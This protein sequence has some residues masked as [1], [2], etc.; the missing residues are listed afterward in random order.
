[1]NWEDEG[2]LIE[3][4]NHGEKNSIIKVL[5]EKHGLCAGLVKG[6]QAKKYRS[7]LS[8]GAQL[9]LRWSARLPEHL[10]MFNLDVIKGRSTLFMG[11]KL[12]LFGFNSLCSMILMFLAERE[13]VEILYLET[14]DLI[15]AIETGSNWLKSY[16]IWEKN[17][18][19]EIGF[20]LELS[21]CA[22][23]GSRQ[24][25]SHVSPKSGKA[26]CRKIAEP[27]KE[28]L[29]K[30]PNFLISA[31]SVTDAKAIELVEGL[32]LTG[33]FFTNWAL[34]EFNKV[35]LPDARIKLIDELNIF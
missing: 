7:T 33:H 28:R 21:V 15:E 1:M 16:V 34:P 5:T 31:E 9:D 20:G 29:L 17:L 12:Q 22:V 2:I 32:A 25:L 30:L 3:L 10:G 35:R 11:G 8:P 19:T 24:N 27:W 6:G 14:R 13:P 4:R 18:L 23:T 26:V